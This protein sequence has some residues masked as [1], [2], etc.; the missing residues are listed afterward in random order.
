MTW[1][2]IPRDFVR[3]SG[4]DARSFLQGQLSQDLDQMRNAPVGVVLTLCSAASFGFG[5]VWIKRRPLRLAPPA[6]AGWQL[7]IGGL[8]FAAVWL[9]VVR[10]TDPLDAP[11]SAWFAVLLIALVSNAIAYALWFRLVPRL[12]SRLLLS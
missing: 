9:V 5:T 3:V 1:W 11:A 10:S 2:R 8:P 4:P 12:P 7:L 6:L